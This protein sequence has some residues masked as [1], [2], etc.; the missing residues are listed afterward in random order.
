L[1]LKH[2]ALLISSHY[3]SSILGVNMSKKDKLID[4]ADVIAPPSA[5]LPAVAVFLVG[6]LRH[7]L[8]KK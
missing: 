7:H 2:P 8:S 3:Q 5:V 6:L 4:V 1:S